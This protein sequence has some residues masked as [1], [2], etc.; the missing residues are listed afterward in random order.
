MIENVYP[1]SPLQEG[2]YYHWL[3]DPKSAVYVDQLIY[4]TQGEIDIEKMRES[5]RKL[6]ARHAILRTFFTQEF[7]DKALQVVLKQAPDTFAYQDCTD[8]NGPTNEDYIKADLAK[9]FNL[10][11][12]SQMRLSVLKV[13]DGIYQFLWSFHH[14]LLDGW[15]VSILIRDFYQFYKGLLSGVEPIME[16]VYPYVNYIQ[17]LGKINQDECVGYW[18]KYLDGYDSLATLPKLSNTA[19]QYELKET[20]VMLPQ[21]NRE[22]MRKFCAD[23]GITEN[24]FFQTVWGILLG[25]YNNTN[26][27]VFGA[28]VSGRPAEVEGIEKMVGLF[29]NT[30]PVRINAG[31]TKTVKE[32]LRQ[33][34]DDAV[35]SIRYHYTQLAQIQAETGVGSNL[36]DHLLVYENYP[37]QDII[38]Q[39]ME[40]EQAENTATQEDIALVGLTSIEQTNYSLNLILMPGDTFTIRFNHNTY[41][42]DEQHISLIAN[43]LLSVFDQ[44]LANPNMLISDINILGEEEKERLLKTFN[45]T[46]VTYPAEKTVTQLFEEQVAA[47]PDKPALAIADAVMTYQQLNE[48]ANQIGHFLRT[49]HN[50]QP[51]DIVAI[52]LPRSHWQILGIL[53]VLKTG[54]AYLP[55]DTDAPPERIANML[56]DCQCKTVINEMALQEWL[57]IMGSQPIENL[58]PVATPE[59]LLYVMYTSGSTGTPKGVQ[60][61]HKAA[62]RLVKN[63]NYV[64]LDDSCILLSTG[65]VAFD[66]T[67]FEY[68]GMLLNGG[69][70][71]LCG[72]ETLLDEVQLANTIQQHKVNMMWFT[73]GWLHQLIDKSPQLFAGLKTILAGGD[74]LSPVHIAKLKELYPSLTII[75]G[76]GPTENTTFSLAHRIDK[77][78]G[79]IPIGKPISNT[80]VYLL[81]E[82][83]QLLP[84]GAVGEICVGGDGLALGYLNQPELTA[85]KFVPNPFAPGQRL[86]KTGDLGQW[87]LD[88]TM[89]FM[90]RRDHQVKIRGYR[91]EL[92]EIE[93]V[94]RSYPNIEDAVVIA[95]EDSNGDKELIAYLTGGETLSDATVLGVYLGGILPF[96]MVP[97]YFVQLPELPLNANGK[98]DRKQLPAPEGMGISSGVE[99]VEPRNETEAKLLKMWQEILLKE[100]ISVKDNFFAIGGHSL[101]ATKLM[102][103]IS[104][105]FEVKL[106]LPVLFSNPTIEHIASEIDKIKLVN[107]EAVINDADDIENISL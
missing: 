37:L 18:K 87:S 3:L 36:L 41:V 62:V 30:V 49:S 68:W 103:H 35:K 14:I 34:Q 63:A 94:L 59:S 47:T 96:Y 86:Y 75:N 98:V 31:G 89:A 85:E 56:A 105:E 17:W 61:P 21:E 15:C 11:S 25:I 12:G 57:P 26:D 70:L 48:V 100:K 42:Y 20:H 54:A 99:Y 38:E 45:D 10:L 93:S 84:L 27:V 23:M 13:A 24:V 72:T 2:I 53:G 51:G 44:V 73:A 92:G 9:G 40:S 77:V 91:I 19:G 107:T 95:R 5:Y 78:N 55:V 60:V 4:T 8:P 104:K 66:A 32:L 22:A 65:A 52:Q 33:I 29:I 69:T 16:R 76:Y 106:S 80:T 6:V 7:G 81:D 71:V 67:T 90:G 43:H 101:K 39:G 97:A 46:V 58:A 79:N 28:V 88:G 102:S 74:K 82:Q 64:Q 1:L 50:I 83:Q